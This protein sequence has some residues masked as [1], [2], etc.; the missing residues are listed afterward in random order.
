MCM[1][2]CLR[3]LWDGKVHTFVY[4]DFILP[5]PRSFRTSGVT[6]GKMQIIF[7]AIYGSGSLS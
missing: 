4:R 3:F 2:E 7:K 5:F 1:G 6:T